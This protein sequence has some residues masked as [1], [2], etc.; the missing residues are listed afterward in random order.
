MDEVAKELLLVSL[1]A[2][3]SSQQTNDESLQLVGEKI[4]A[5]DEVLYSD[6]GFSDRRDD[7]LAEAFALNPE[8]DGE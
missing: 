4:A 3:I 5:G 7:G 1:N 6:L 8:L 2:W